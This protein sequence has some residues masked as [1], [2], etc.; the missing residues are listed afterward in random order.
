[1]P[2]TNNNK[3]IV[4]LPFMELLN[5]TP[6]A[7]S[8]LAAT[9]YPRAGGE[10]IYYIAPGPLLYRY[11]T[12]ADTWQQL[13]T[14]PT[15][16][17]GLVSLRTT[18]RRGFHGRVLAASTSSIVIPALRGAA[19][20]GSTLVIDRGIGAAQERVLNFVSESVFDSGVIT[21]TTTAT[22]ADAT[23]KWKINQWSG[24]IAG[25]TLNTGA[26][27]YKN[28]LYNDATTLYFQDNNLQPHD[29]WNNQV[30]VATA[31]Y[32]LPVT[33]AGSQAHYQIMASSYTTNTPWEV[34]PDFTSYFT[35][36]TGG[37]YLLSSAGTTPFMSLQYYDMA[38]DLWQTKTVP[39]NLL[40]AALGTDAS[41]ENIIKIGTPLL[42]P[43]SGSITATT[44]S[45]S[46]AGLNIQVDRFA[47]HRIYI[48]SG[49][50]R[51]QDRRITGNNSG[52]FWI[53][54]AWN[55]TPDNT[56]RYEIYQDNDQAYTSIG[57]NSALLAYSPDNDWWSQ[58]YT[59]D[60]GIT[61]NASVVMNGW[62]S[63][64]IASST[65]PI[66][67][68]I[69]AIS[70]TP[71]A[72]GTGYVIGDILTCAVGGAGAQVLVT[73]VT[74][75]GVVTGL[76]LLNSGTT[77]GY[78][79]GTGRATT[80]GS[81]T[82]CTINI[83][84]VGKTANV[85]TATATWFKTGD[86]VTIFGCNEAAW[87]GAY[88]ILGVSSVTTTQ[89]VFSVTTAANSA[90]TAAN[91][92]STTVI[93]D[94][95]KN[96]IPNEHVG[97][98]VHLMV[99]GTA[100]TSQIRW[101]TANTATTLTVNTITA[102]GNGTS[103]YVIYDAKAYGYDTTSR[104][105]NATSYGWA[106]GSGQATNTLVDITKNWIPN[107]WSGSAFKVEA[108]TGYGSGR[109]TILS[110]SANSLFYAAQTFT[111]DASTKYEIA[112]TWGLSAAAGTTAG[113]S[114]SLIPSWSLNYFAG[115]RV[116]ITGGTTGLA[117][118][119]SVT[120]NVQNILVTGAIT[121]PSADATFCILSKPPIGAG[122]NLLWTYGASDV[123]K[124]ARY[125]YLFRGGGSNTFDIYDI[126]S[127]TWT[128]GYFFDPQTETFTTGTSYAY[129]GVDTIYMVKGIAAATPI[130]VFSYN[131]NS[132]TARGVITSTIL[133]GTPTIG[134]MAEV[135]TSQDGL[136][137]IYILQNTGTQFTR[138]L[139]SF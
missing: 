31:P 92:Q 136:K 45:L 53:T 123:N 22:L 113:I 99:A 4:D 80:G 29:P 47:N 58:G 6:T 131:I 125:L 17:S 63:I 49:S 108:G 117:Q 91:S 137:Y 42:G 23:K 59:F 72:G 138:G 96:W 120:S 115:K 44:R 55:T 94:S 126:S 38:N 56:S 109:I 122:S 116:R 87:N 75:G 24:Y 79:V 19:L 12:V 30:F 40:T 68:G 33:T 5:Q 95:T 1:M 37:L 14:P 25:I 70:S 54:P 121:A 34:I 51:G 21:G 67:A 130:R 107:Q 100:P 66:A 82:G 81:G 43:R 52:S 7:T 16:T 15:A 112:D 32:A 110:S 61:T 119:T 13:A 128:F 106:S 98:L 90:I 65:A 10:F 134:N 62:A 20:S 78:T 36:F 8:A 83:T 89:C 118:E 35:T 28:I 124:R 133:Q 114:G 26:T 50:G 93:V 71:T 111:P 9:S 129:D 135:V 77:T 18:S 73:S 48:T 64:G 46:D 101:I 139:L 97:R 86:P 132:T 69:T 60:G 88:T 76:E 2:V 127:G 41:F 39:Q 85:T 74:T 57:A 27:T 102:A 11:D 3:R 84:A 105:A 104:N 103:K